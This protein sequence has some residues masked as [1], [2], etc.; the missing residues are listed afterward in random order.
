[1]AKLVKGNDVIVSFYDT[2]AAAWKPVGCETSHTFTE[3]QEITTSEGN[4]CSPTPQKAL[5]AYDY[6]L[7]ID[8]EMV[9]SDDPDF[10]DKSSYEFMRGLAKTQRD[11]NEP[12][13]WALLGGNED[14]YGTAYISELSRDGSFG[15]DAT[16]SISL[17]GIGETEDTDP[18]GL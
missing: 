6:T 13:Q 12:I 7:S 5:G 3:T 17:D 11:D 14:V 9:A 15:E 8:A 18:N 2:T 16:F 10:S 1:M 4:K